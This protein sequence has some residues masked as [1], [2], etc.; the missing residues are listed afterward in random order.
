M[1]PP[2]STKALVESLDHC[3]LGLTHVHSTSK[4][5]PHM[6]WMCLSAHTPLAGRGNG[7]DR[8]EFWRIK[9]LWQF[10]F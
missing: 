5:M 2:N 10:Y 6:Q 1:P 4:N 8:L 7:P 9:T 3:D